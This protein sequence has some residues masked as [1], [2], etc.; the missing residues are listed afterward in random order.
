MLGENEQ[1]LRWQQAKIDQLQEQLNLLLHKRF[2]PSSEKA[3]AEQ[4]SLFNEAEADEEPVDEDTQVTI[5]AEH[6][7]KKRGRKALPESLP[8]IRVEHDLPES[9]KSCPCGCQ[10]TRIGEEISEQ[11]DIIPAKVQVIQNVRFKYACKGGCE[12]TIKTAPLPAQPIPKSNASPG[13]LAHIAVSKYQDALPLARQE[14][15]LQRIGVDIPRATLANWMIHLGRLI[16]PLINLMCETLLGYDILG[17]DETPIQVLK[18]VGRSPTTNSYMWVQRGGPP[19]QPVV[20]FH[21]APSRGHGVVLELLPDYQG[22]VQVDGYEAYETAATL[23]PGITL[24]GCMAHARRKFDE[25]VKAQ[26]KNPRTGKA[27]MGLSY[28]RK[29]YRLEK[30]L[31]DASPEGRYLARQAQAKPIL[32]ALREWLDKSLPEVPPETLTGKA[33]NYLNN[34]WDK[35]IRY[36]DDG[37]LSID[38][39]ATERTIRPFVIGRRNWL[40]S[41]TPKGASASANL[42]SLIETCKANGLEPYH[43]LRYLFRELP[44]AQSLEQIESLLPFN[45]ETEKLSITSTVGQGGG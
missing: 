22:F 32:D 28:I 7:R 21:Y 41:D 12:E 29:L 6:E 17:M 16:Q 1:S 15:I 4:L 45:M 36:L 18:E 20:L 8:R 24:V 23:L 37:R 34:Q 13:L 43:Y 38:N 11:L 44:K 30:T 2:A 3:P 19:G 33:L 5:I 39:N 27:M 25:A 26:G 35:L 10:L 31:K 14:K 40:F 9:A 42:Y